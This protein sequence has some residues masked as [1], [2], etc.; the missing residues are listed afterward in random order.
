[1]KNK[2][3]SELNLFSYGSCIWKNHR[4]SILLAFSF[5]LFF[6]TTVSAALNVSL[7]NQGT[8]VRVKSTGELLTL[9]N[10]TVTL[11][12]SLTGGNL[13]YNETFIDAI[14]NGSWGVMLGENSSNP[15]PLEFGRI[16]YFDYEI[17]GSDVNFTNFNGTSVGRQF[18]YSPLGDVNASDLAS[19]IA[20][21][22]TGNFTTT[23][24]GFFGW[25][26]SLGTRITGLFIQDINFNGTITGTG[27]ITTT[28]NVT[29][30]F[31]I[32]DGSQ[33]TNIPAGSLGT[34][35]NTT[36]I[37]DGTIVDADIAANAINTS[38]ILDGNV[39]DVKISSLNWTKLNSVPVGFSDNID[40]N[41]IY[42]A[43]GI[44][45]F[46]NGSDFFFLNETK[47]NST[48]DELILLNET[49][50]LY[51]FDSGK[52]IFLN[53]TKL[54]ETINLIG[55]YSAGDGITITGKEINT[56]LGTSIDN[57]EIN[58]NVINTTQIIDGT[59][60]DTDISD[61]TNLTLG[62][63][64]VFALG[65]VIQNIISGQV[66]LN[67]TLNVT[68]NLIVEGNL[69]VDTNTLFVDSDN[70]RVGIGTTTPNNP[71]EIASTTASMRQTRWS[72][73]STDGAGMVIQRSRGSS[74]GN[75]TIVQDGDKIA[76]FNFR[77]YSGGSYVRAALIQVFVDG[78]PGLS[79]MP[80]RLT[81]A[82]SA[83]G[84]SSPTE[85]L[86]IDSLGNVGI[87]T[88]SPT[89]KL[90]VNGGVNISGVY[91]GNGSGLTDIGASSLL[92]DSIN[93]TQSR[94]F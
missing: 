22:T 16:Y 85:R 72:D 29:A 39:T 3:I 14:V 90:D 79:D 34:T 70:N 8:E 40:N 58:S 56:T 73:V 23:G 9:G 61:S 71:L 63:K 31:F 76:S 13:I 65:G 54:N 84:S 59:I 62:Q 48:I 36:E 38:H 44:Y 32:G 18:F 21:N 20:I 66:D 57:S 91:Y 42:F 69:T 45:I 81:F 25:L 89:Q 4:F 93:T 43:G 28:G 51:I 33:L 2:K 94:Y 64:I 83:D 35:I 10:L 5:I 24:T 37:E 11:W 60:T 6:T 87:G 46:N 92:A 50:G 55:N 15:L 82:T 88:T 52:K 49:N 27:N 30:D 47:L 41:T 78:T 86:R 74:I 80:G 12:D 75:D 53:E 68:D 67:G 17:D 7:S 26:G 19:D 1:M 77:G